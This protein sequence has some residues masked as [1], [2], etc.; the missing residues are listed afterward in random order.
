[1]KGNLMSKT[2]QLSP[3]LLSSALSRRTLLGG[4]GLG[5]LSLILA[6]CSSESLASSAS[7]RV[8]S[9]QLTIYNANITTL[10]PRRNHGPVGRSL[11]DSVIDIDP[12][13]L[14]LKPW[15]A[16]S[17]SV[18]DDNTEFTFK[19]RND[20]T[21][22]DGTAFNAS[23][24]K[25]NLDQSAK[26]VTDGYGWYFQGLFDNYVETRVVN[27]SEAVVRFSKPA[28]AFL[29]TLATLQLA[30]VAPS[31]FENSYDDRK[32]GKFIGSGPYV[33]EKYTPNEQITL[34]RREEYKWNSGLASHQ[35]PASVKKIYIKFVD[36]QS[37]RESALQAG[38]T[39]V[40]QNPTAEQAD[41]LVSSGYQLNYRAQSGIPYSF[42]INFSIPAL[43]DIA[44]RRAIRDAIDR[45]KI[46]QNITGTREPKASSVLT[47]QT[48]GYADQSQYITYD[49]DGAAKRLD[50]AGWAVGSDGIREKN[51]E[52]LSFRLVNWWEPKTVKDTLQLIKEQLS[53]VGIE[54]NIIQELSG[55]GNWTG[56]SSQLHLN[57]ATRADGGLALYS[58]YTDANL[59]SASLIEG[60]KF[61]S[62][63]SLTEPGSNLSEIVTQQI[64]EGDT[65][66]R[67]A[68]L[69]QAQAIII[70]DA[71]RIPIYNNINSESGFY[72]SSAQ[73][74]GLRNDTLSELVLADVWSAK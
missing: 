65:A 57:N 25:T 8:E 41:S 14:E 56:G 74:H 9:D 26:Q 20:V 12:D 13:T 35:G 48:P 36:E 50:E 38:E 71:L 30:I 7:E 21:F 37:V 66:K 31:S 5:A 32:A 33:L 70:R 58:Q 59:A 23:V 45:D 17:W 68:L 40:A 43:Q 27:D 24:L 3:Q 28:P 44:V 42:V 54:V 46:T 69:A 4:A 34:V 51:G 10:D 67:A 53:K 1:M 6:G 52:R 63:E 15:L 18:N 47:P 62:L 16:S 39:D 11:A 55:S 72:A 29:P 73:V 2:S 61:P 64:T 49:P 19:L 60:A 22:S